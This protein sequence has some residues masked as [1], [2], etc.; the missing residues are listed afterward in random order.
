MPTL[1]PDVQRKAG[2]LPY[3]D[4]PSGVRSLL[5]RMFHGASGG[6]GSVDESLD[7]VH[8]CSTFGSNPF[9]MGFARVSGENMDSGR[10]QGEVAVSWHLHT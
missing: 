4:D 10:E 5:S 6:G 1:L 7:L 8:L 9:V 3:A 2:A